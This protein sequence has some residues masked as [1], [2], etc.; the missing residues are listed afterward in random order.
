MRSKTPKWEKWIYVAVI[1]SFFQLS[2]G[3][4]L[5]AI[6]GLLTLILMMLMAI[7]YIMVEG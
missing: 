2:M 5:Q 6:W 1:I 3:W 7:V 4:H